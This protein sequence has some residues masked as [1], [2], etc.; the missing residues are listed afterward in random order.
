MPCAVLGVGMNEFELRPAT[1]GE[2]KYFDILVDDRPLAEFLLAALALR[3]IPSRL[4]AHLNR[5]GS[6]IG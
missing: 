2:V 5:A 4:S 3:R 1:R 6:A